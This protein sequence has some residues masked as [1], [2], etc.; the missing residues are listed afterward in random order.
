MEAGGS[1]EGFTMKSHSAFGDLSV[2]AFLRLC[3]AENDRRLADYDS[4]LLRPQLVPSAVRLALR[5]LRPDTT[6]APKSSAV[7]PVSKRPADA[8]EAEHR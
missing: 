5:F 1:Q 3:V 4:R 8:A 6:A 7:P 2:S